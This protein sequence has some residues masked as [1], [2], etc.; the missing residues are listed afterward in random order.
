MH[1]SAFRSAILVVGFLGAYAAAQD[2]TP[3]YPRMILINFDPIIESEGGQRLHTV[4]GWNN[5]ASLTNGYLSDLRQT[6]HDLNWGR[7]IR[8]VNADV[9][10]IKTD[11]FRY[12]DDS[13]LECL[14][15]WSGW[16]TPDCIDLPDA[17][18]CRS[19]PMA[20]RVMLV[21][22]DNTIPIPIPNST[23]PGRISAPVVV[24]E[25]TSWRAASPAPVSAI[26]ER[27]TYFG[28]N[29][30]ENFAPKMAKIKTPNDMGRRM[31]PVS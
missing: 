15:T 31:T 24:R 14:S 9:F 25:K 29:H 6:S 11:G 7:L 20:P 22:W 21:I 3:V 10:P 4:G 26:P 5:P 17:S 1:K 30:V 19:L 8:T 23:L 12:T 27:R 28:S 2:A 18:V 16:H 13:Y